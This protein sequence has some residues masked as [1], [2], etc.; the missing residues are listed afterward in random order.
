MKN[1]TIVPLVINGSL[2]SLMHLK[3][4]I[5]QMNIK[6]AHMQ[7]SDS[8]PNFFKNCMSKPYLL[9]LLHVA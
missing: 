1:F 9:K 6:K 2:L 7:M 8:L 4:L 5:V 3:M